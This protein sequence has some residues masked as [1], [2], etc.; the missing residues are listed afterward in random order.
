MN[1][2]YEKTPLNGGAPG[3]AFK[4]IFNGS[5]KN[6]AETMAREA[7]QN[8]VDAALEPMSAVEIDFRFVTLRTADRLAFEKA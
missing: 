2:E 1:W 4:S 6:H 7:I 8:S 5:G 3:D